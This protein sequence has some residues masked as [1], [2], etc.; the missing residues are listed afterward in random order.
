MNAD[1]AKNINGPT[2]STVL[3]CHINPIK[4]P[5]F[6]RTSIE[7]FKSHNPNVPSSRKHAMHRQ[8]DRLSMRRR[9]MPRDAEFVL[10]KFGQCTLVTSKLVSINKMLPRF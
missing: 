5:L 6:D 10:L 2:E 9:F 8:V 1:D 7:L 3:F 4:V